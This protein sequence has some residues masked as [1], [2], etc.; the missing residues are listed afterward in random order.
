MANPTSASWSNAPITCP[1]M[2][3][4]SNK[5]AFG[6]QVA[7]A[8]SPDGKLH[9]DTLLELPHRHRW[10]DSNVLAI[11]RCHRLC[12]ILAAHAFTPSGATA[13]SSASPGSKAR[14]TP[15]TQQSQRVEA[16]SDCLHRA[17]VANLVCCPQRG[18]RIHLQVPCQIYR[19]KQHI[20]ELLPRPT[21]SA[22][23]H[24]QRLRPRSSAISS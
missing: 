4:A 14:P 23:L 24:L 13:F 6:N 9:L 18:L 20:A 1:P 5:Y 22:R 7:I 16:P 15:R 10:A 19:R 17:S 21:P 8:V 2:R 11:L 3:S 12:G